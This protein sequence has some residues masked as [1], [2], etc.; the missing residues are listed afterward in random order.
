MNA[1]N[2]E[3]AIYYVPLIKTHRDAAQWMCDFLVMD[4]NS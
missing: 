1:K 2:E 3:R 4:H